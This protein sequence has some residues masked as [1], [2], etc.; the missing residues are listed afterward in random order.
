VARPLR[1][2][3][4]GGIYHVASRGNRKQPIYR[5]D[6]DRTLWLTTLDS[7]V[8]ACG[9]ICHAYCLMTNHFH[10]VV[11]TPE[12]NISRGMQRLNATHADW[13]NWRYGFNGHLFQGRFFSQLAKSQ[14][15]L[16]E[17]ARYVVLNPVRAGLCSSAVAW[18]WSSLRATIGLVPAPRFLTTAWILAQFDPQPA[19]AVQMYVEFVEEGEAAVASAD[20]PGS[21]PGMF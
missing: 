1:A 5:D 16:L 3:I 9:W 2:Q 17:L 19:T 21:G 15:H 10:L 18:R 4:P 12:P 7:T 20:M 13:I 14:E 8:A 6:A 11:E